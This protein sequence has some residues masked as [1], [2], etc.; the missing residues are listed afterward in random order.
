[1]RSRWR[2]RTRQVAGKNSRGK[3]GMQWGPFRSTPRYDVAVQAGS[4]EERVGGRGRDDIGGHASWGQHT[5]RMYS[6]GG[7]VRGREGEGHG[8]RWRRSCRKCR[9]MSKRG[10]CSIVKGRVYHCLT[11]PAEVQNKK[12]SRK[13]GNGSKLQFSMEYMY[14]THMG[15]T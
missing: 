15:Q 4:R 11:S 8:C 12:S 1:M 9:L 5:R 3:S 6:R 2:R 7:Q 10:P 13:P 14:T